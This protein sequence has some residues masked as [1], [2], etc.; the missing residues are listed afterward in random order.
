ML[1]SCKGSVHLGEIRNSLSCCEQ[2]SLSTGQ[3]AE[4]QCFKI[5]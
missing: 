5:I 1:I 2:R 4:K 3:C